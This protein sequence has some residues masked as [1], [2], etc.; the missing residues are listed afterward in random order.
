MALPAKA[1]ALLVE[2]SQLGDRID[3]ALESL[4]L[5]H[6]LTTRHVAQRDLDACVARLAEI[7]LELAD[8]IG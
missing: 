2:Q 6:D 3:L 4:V 1:H 7:D 8:I 5:S